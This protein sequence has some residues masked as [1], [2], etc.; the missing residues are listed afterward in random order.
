MLKQII[1]GCILILLF[2]CVTEPELNYV[3][4]QYHDSEIVAGERIYYV[5][6][7]PHGFEPDGAFIDNEPP[8]TNYTIGAWITEGKD[9]NYENKKWHCKT[10]KRDHIE[11]AVKD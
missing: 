2:S 7:S 8:G 3:T 1:I 6:Y 11:I 9:F 5:T 10:V 4:I